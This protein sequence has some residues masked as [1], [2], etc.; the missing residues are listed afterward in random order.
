MVFKQ[1]NLTNR[2]KK[3]NLHNGA[4]K[5]ATQCKIFKPQAENEETDG[6]VI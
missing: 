6:R 1:Q 5:G 3:C 4:C 2:G